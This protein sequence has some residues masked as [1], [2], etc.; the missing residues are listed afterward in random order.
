MILT[1]GE[2]CVQLSVPVRGCEVSIKQLKV[3]LAVFNWFNT[4][5]VE[6]LWLRGNKLINSL[7]P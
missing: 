3:G 7:L 2:Q 4:G 5:T 1:H 6:R